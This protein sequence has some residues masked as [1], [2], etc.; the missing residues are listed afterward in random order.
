MSNI[1][2]CVN[3]DWLEVF[4]NEDGKKLDYEYFRPLYE[5]E[6]RAYGTPQYREMFTIQRYRQPLIEIRRDPYSLKSRG[7]MFPEGAAHIRLSN[8]SCYMD[9]PIQFLCSFLS[10]HGYI[11][12]SLTR[13]DICCDF[14]HFDNMANPQKFLNR[15]LAMDFRKINQC[16]IATHGVDMW[17]GFQYNSV[18]WGTERSPITTRFYNK[19]LELSEVKEKLYIKQA[20]EDAGLDIEKV[21]RVEFAIRSKIK[22]WVNIDGEIKR[23]D[24]EF[25]DSREKILS[26][27]EFLAS[28]YFH[29]KYFDRHLDG[30]P[31]RKDRCRDYSLFFL[32]SEP[33]KPLQ[34]SYCQDP[35]YKDKLF[36]KYC[37][38][39]VRNNSD[40][41]MTTREAFMRVIQYFR[42]HRELPK[43]FHASELSL[44]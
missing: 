14:N 28:K 35:T 8:R 42:L 15:Y 31:L 29:F 19:S 13:I 12:E 30:S 21:W 2:R 4:V 37:V 32:P 38:E 7:G 6:R 10:R 27:F 18:R 43:W 34:H 25:Y 36:I 22:H 1:K 11:Y 40:L 39:I 16:K 17:D 41:D 3:I 24:V 26:V 9:N 44:F 20:W 33:Y 23:N 5:C